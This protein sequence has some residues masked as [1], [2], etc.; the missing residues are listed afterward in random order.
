MHSTAS[1]G[2]DESFWPRTQALYRMLNDHGFEVLTAN[3]W[4]LPSRTFFLCLP[5]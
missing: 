4:Y 3:P 2:N 1:W 5:R